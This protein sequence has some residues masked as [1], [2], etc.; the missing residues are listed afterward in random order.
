MGTLLNTSGGGNGTGTGTQ[1]VKYKIGS[2]TYMGTMPITGVL[3][4]EH[5]LYPAVVLNPPC[6]RVL[7]DFSPVGVDSDGSV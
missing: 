6:F 2:Y 7:A 5:H 1:Y 4:L 3:A